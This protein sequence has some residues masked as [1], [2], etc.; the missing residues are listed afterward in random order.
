MPT[1]NELRDHATELLNEVYGKWWHHTWIIKYGWLQT[2]VSVAHRTQQAIQKL[3]TLTAQEEAED[4]VEIFSGAV[5]GLLVFAWH[6]REKQTFESYLLEE[7][8]KH[9]DKHAVSLDTLRASGELL[10]ALGEKPKP[11]DFDVAHWFLTPLQQL[12]E[13]AYIKR[14]QARDLVTPSQDTPLHERLIDMCRATN[15][16]PKEIIHLNGEDWEVMDG[17]GEINLQIINYILWV[18]QLSAPP[19][20]LSRLPSH[21]SDIKLRKKKDT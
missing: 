14:A 15:A 17:Q 12:Q 11:G 13:P 21:L 7:L 8:C 6:A 5:K 16:H 18:A 10:K 3:L 4:H 1:A 9:I 19:E 2:S 20:I